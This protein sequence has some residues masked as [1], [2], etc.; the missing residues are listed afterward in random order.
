MFV[1]LLSVN[2]AAFDRYINNRNVSVATTI[3]RGTCKTTLATT[4]AKQQLHNTCER[5]IAKQQLQN[6][7]SKVTLA[8]YHLHMN[9]CKTT[10]TTR[11]TKK[12][13]ISK[14]CLNAIYY[15]GGHETPNKTFFD[16]D[17]CRIA[18]Q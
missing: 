7:I 6:T 9:E 4:L 18:R 16:Y 10:A 14:K 2:L 1:G 12:Q 5:T 15:T 17:V 11:L 3:E 13:S 8:T